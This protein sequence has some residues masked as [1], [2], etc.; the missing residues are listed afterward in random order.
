MK[1]LFIL[2]TLI[3]GL[4]CLSLYAQK[5]KGKEEDNTKAMLIKGVINKKKYI[6]YCD[7]IYPQR[8]PSRN[9]GREYTVEMKGEKFRSY[10]PYMGVAHAAS[11]DGM[12]I[13]DFEEEYYDYKCKEGK[14]G[15][16]IVSFKVKNGQETLD[17]SITIYPNGS[18]RIY[19][20]PLRR[21]PVSFSG[22]MALN[23]KLK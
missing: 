21:D 6:I 5:D 13:L 8:G 4:G 17:Y 2:L 10:L 14:K 20:Q 18:V 22:E 9:V 23:R 7:R 3:M 11:Y 12:N 15:Q 19:I 16:Y 1:R